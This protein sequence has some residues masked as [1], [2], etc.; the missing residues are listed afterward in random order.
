MVTEQNIRDAYLFLRKKN[1][2]IPDEALEYIKD[3]CLKQLKTDEFHRKCAVVNAHPDWE[4]KNS[5]PW[6]WKLGTRG[7]EEAYE[8]IQK[9][10]PS[11]EENQRPKEPVFPDEVYIKESDDKPSPPPLPPSED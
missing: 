5:H 2:T 9:D 1:T 10:E 11:A 8:I 6:N 4:I 3:T 7:Y